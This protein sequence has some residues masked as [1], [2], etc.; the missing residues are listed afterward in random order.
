[1]FVVSIDG[2]VTSQSIITVLKF[3]DGDPADADK[4]LTLFKVWKGNGKTDHSKDS[5]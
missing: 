5:G 1:M 3:Y 2:R 4:V